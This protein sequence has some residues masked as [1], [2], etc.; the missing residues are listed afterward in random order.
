M[1]RKWVLDKFLIL[2]NGIQKLMPSNLQIALS[3]HYCLI[4]SGE[5]VR[6]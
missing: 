4:P 3:F 5:K 1:F 2:V 6:W